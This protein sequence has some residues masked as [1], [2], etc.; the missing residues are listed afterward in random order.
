[1]FEREKYWINYYNSYNNGY[2][3]T[4]G[5][6]QGPIRKGELNGKS[7]LTNEEVYNIRKLCLEKKI[8]LEV[9]ELYKNKISKSTFE[10]IWRGET[11]KDILPEAIEYVKTKEYISSVRKFAKSKQNKNEKI[12]IEI[13]ERK[14]GGENRLVVYE[15]YKNI[16]SLS[17]FNKIWY[18]KI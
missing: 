14:K 8:P 4:L 1:M 2:N 9:F 12:R 11:W 7:I 6:D 18:E 10:H 5:G 16:Y 17:G 13:K 15:D 3:E